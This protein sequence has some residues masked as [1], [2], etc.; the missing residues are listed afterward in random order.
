M[1]E[2]VVASANS[3]FFAVFADALAVFAGALAVSLFFAGAHTVPR[4]FVVFEGSLAV[5]WFFAV[6]VAF[7]RFFRGCSHG[8]AV[9]RGCSRGFAD[10]EGAL[11]DFEGALA[12]SRFFRGCTR[13]CYGCLTVSRFSWVHSLSLLATVVMGTVLL[14]SVATAIS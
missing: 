12:D 13:G 2:F 3:W 1:V 9:F 8:F 11:T 10:F 6:A 5:S 14:I 4:F 7:S